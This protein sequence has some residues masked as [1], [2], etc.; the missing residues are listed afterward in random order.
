M[1]MGTTKMA[2]TTKMMTTTTV[3]TTTTTM[4]TWLE[5]YVEYAK[6]KSYAKRI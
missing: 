5:A 3:T 4:L 1:R 2:M 6:R